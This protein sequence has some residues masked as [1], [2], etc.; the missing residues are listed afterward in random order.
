M[1]FEGFFHGSLKLFVKKIKQSVLLLGA[2]LYETHERPMV[3]N[4]ESLRGDTNGQNTNCQREYIDEFCGLA[5][6]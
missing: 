6:I 4:N 3:R 2:L 1:V 5:E